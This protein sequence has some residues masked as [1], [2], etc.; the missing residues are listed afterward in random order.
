LD[1]VAKIRLPQTELL[2]AIS[3]LFSIMNNSVIIGTGSCLP[4]K[5]VPNSHFLQ[6]TFYKKDGQP[7][8]KDTKEITS[9]LRIRRNY[10][11]T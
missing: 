7:M 4:E 3:I 10:H 11:C 9:K 6:H 2:T 8:L 5:I 1:G